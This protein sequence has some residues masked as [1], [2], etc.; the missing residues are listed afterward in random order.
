M[1]RVLKIVYSRWLDFSNNSL[2]F[3][4]ANTEEFYNWAQEEV[5]KNNLEPHGE[6]DRI[7]KID[8]QYFYNNTQS[9]YYFR[10]SN[11]YFH[12]KKSN[13]NFVKEEQIDNNGI[14][15]YPI[16]I[17]CNT[18]QFILNPSNKYDFANTLSK[19][20]LSALQSGL[21]KILLI[22]MVDPSIH[23]SESIKL[24]EYL[25][26]L[27]INEVWLLQGNI[28][29]TKH[30]KIKFFDSIISL[31]QT[32]NEME[33]Y[34][35]Q[36]SLGYIS[37]FVREIKDKKRDK[38]FL[39]FNRFMHRP[40]RTGLA[41]L[42][43]EH[44]LLE[45][46][47][48][49]FLYCPD[50]NYRDLLFLLKLPAHNADKIKS[51][52]PYQLDTHHLIA[53]ELPRFHSVTNFL[54]SL[55]ENSYIHIIT[56]TDFEHVDTPFFSEKTWRPILNLQ[57]FLY[58]GNPNS[59]AKLRELGFKTFEPFIDESYDLILDDAERFAAISTEI[60][61]LNKL[62]IDEIHQWVMFIKDTLVY[63]QKLLY[64]Y[65]TYNPLCNLLNLNSY[66]QT[67]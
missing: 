17:E 67:G 26:S 55:Y 64:S 43:I 62:S 42:A 40:H 9:T 24:I 51:M 16:E 12:C 47:Y 44:N 59:L 53:D 7:D 15:L 28:R 3:P 1:D 32:A 46:G 66:T 22:N 5:K 34:P 39:S 58:M 13:I 61:K 4:N 10:N 23:D 57:P 31:Y 45:N 50:N 33:K 65:K 52:V 48:F 11:F 30:K 19:Q 41:H 63:N 37:D 21:C 56:E 2:P 35:Y 25:E 8:E 60:I 38:K 18:L 54:L 29:N 49:S 6:F 27:G 20:L 36:T 14:Y